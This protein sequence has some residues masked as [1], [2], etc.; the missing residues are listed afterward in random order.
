VRKYQFNRLSEYI[1]FDFFMQQNYFEILL[2]KPL[3]GLR[4]ATHGI[5][6]KTG[7]ESPRGD[8]CSPAGFA[9]APKGIKPIRLVRQI[10]RSFS[11]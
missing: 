11:W 8:S 1:V 4:K 6:L 5:R 3:D 2:R 10:S 7:I 9:A